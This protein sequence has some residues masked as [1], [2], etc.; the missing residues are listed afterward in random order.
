MS[1]HTASPGDV[2][3]MDGFN[4]RVSQPHF[5]DEAGCTYQYGGVKDMVVNIHGKTL[6]NVCQN[7]D[8]VIVNIF[9]V[10]EWTF[11]RKFAL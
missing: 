10:W 6:V 2:I 4:G 8:L 3:I 7:N 5:V 1:S 11:H 9:F